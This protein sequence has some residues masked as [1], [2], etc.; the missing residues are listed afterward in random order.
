MTTSLSEIFDG[1]R[2]AH[3]VYKVTGKVDE[4]GKALGRA[5]TVLG[6]PGPDLWDKHL[7]GEVGLGVVPINEDNLC[8]W[9][10]ID[11]DS[12]QGHDH[13]ALDAKVLALGLPLVQCLSKS[14]GSHLY[15]F[16][17]DWAPAALVRRRLEYMAVAI[18]HRGVEVFPKQIKLGGPNDTG[19][20]INMPYFGTARP[21]TENGQP[22]PLERFLELVQARRISA[23]DL[24]ALTVPMPGGTAFKDGPPCLQHLAEHKVSAGGRNEALFAMGVY[25]RKKYADD[26]EEKL[27]YANREFLAVPLSSQEVS[28]LVK[29]LRR[30]DYA[31]PCSKPVLSQCCV[32]DV[33]KRRQ[34]G[35]GQGDED[36]GLNIGSLTK[37]LSDPPVWI[38]DVE[39]HRLQLETDDLMDQRRF[40]KIVFERLNHIYHPVAPKAWTAMLQEKLN[41]LE[42]EKAPD[43]ADTAGRLK[44]YLEQFL[45]GQTPARAREELLLGKPWA[46]GGRH[47][48]RAN[49]LLRYLEQQHFRD[50]TPRRLWSA[51]RGMGADHSQF[52]V[53]GKNLQVWHVPE[54]TNRIQDDEEAG[55]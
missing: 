37:Q 7:R 18:G 40:R 47:Y 29:S 35:V 53:R 49:D 3:G 12:Y 26:W 39:G 48:F 6:P 14:G 17:S 36:I 28:A 42:E 27:D 20:W 5:T 30:K 54:A 8:R 2:R 10:A 45:T 1:L 23:E 51:L 24:E 31:Y 16:L 11:I 50:M 21:A 46:E 33:C 38:L 19:N 22:V 4:R 32:K 55:F 52:T 13:A 25:C 15:L 34:Y 44:W 9:G 41:S 43:E